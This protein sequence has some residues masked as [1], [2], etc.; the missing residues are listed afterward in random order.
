MFFLNTD[1]AFTERG[2][3]EEDARGGLFQ[4]LKKQGFLYF[5]SYTLL[6]M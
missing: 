1:S 5:K 2:D 3:G 4:S 6:L